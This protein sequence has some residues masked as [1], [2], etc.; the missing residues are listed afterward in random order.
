M[1]AMHDQQLDQR[2]TSDGDDETFQSEVRD[3]IGI[4]G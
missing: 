1:M 4:D 3:V 2:E